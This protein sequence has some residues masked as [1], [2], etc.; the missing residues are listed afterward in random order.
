MKRI[1]YQALTLASLVLTLG[2]TSYAQT[3]DGS[4]STPGSTRVLYDAIA[5]VV[6]NE[7]VLV[8]DVM[9]RAI[10]YARQ[11]KIDP[12]DSRLQRQ[13]LNDLIDEKLV[14]TRAREDS[15]TVSE[16]LVS[17]RLEYQ[18][19]N[20]VQQAG[21]EQRLEQLYGMPMDKLRT[22]ARDLIR[23]QLIVQKMVQKKFS[24]L[25]VTDRDLTE[26][27]RKYRD[28][29]DNQQ[30]P[31]QVE[32]RRIVLLSKPGESSKQITVD[33]LAAIK[34]SIAAG[35]DFADFARRY[36]Q[37]P[38]SAAEGGDVG[39]VQPG[40]L[41]PEYEQ[42]AAKLDINEISD[43]V[44]STYGIHLIQLLDRRPDGSFRSRH[45]LRK[46]EASDT[47]KQALLDSL[48]QLRGRSLSGT[49][50]AELAREYS[51]DPETAPLG[52]MIGKLPLTQVPAQIRAQIEDLPEL[53]ISE[54]M[55]I[56][57]TG[58]QSGYAIV[59][60]SRRIPAHS[61]DPTEDRAALEELA[62][63][64]K[65][66]EQYADWVQELRNEIYWE[67]KTDPSLMN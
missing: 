12:S 61:F 39:F 43:P 24:D 4:G 67:I 25:K 3:G 26:F 41:V 45:I 29:L 5:A 10:M 23:Q 35:G 6:G 34:D 46:I 54:P 64:N 48:N 47:E 65:Q 42:A 66:E 50:F 8:S 57:L 59:Q 49:S 40:T 32:L 36:S 53:G 63:R 13:F 31:E 27:Y 60:V 37:D 2:F 7:I 56:Q 28:S 62:L 17:Q 55:P 44:E 20:L 52:G 19:R 21:S 9:Q 18:L 14:L 15:I 38:G 58:S 11:A 33:L 30:I 22:E 51:Q 16:E 1:V